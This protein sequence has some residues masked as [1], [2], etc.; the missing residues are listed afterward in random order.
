MP[1]SD[2]EEDDADAQKSANPDAQN[3]AS[4]DELSDWEMKEGEESSRSIVFRI[5]NYS[6]SL[7]ILITDTI[8]KREKRLGK[9]K[10]KKLNNADESAPE[11]EESASTHPEILPPSDEQSTFFEMN[12]SRPLM[13]VIHLRYVFKYYWSSASFQRVIS[14]NRRSELRAS[15]AD[16]GENNS[17]CLRR[18]WYLRLCRYRYR[19]NSRI[20]AADPRTITVQTEAIH[21]CYPV[22]HWALLEHT[23]DSLPPI[24]RLL[25]LLRI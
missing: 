7:L 4:D 21:S 10:R 23:I 20:Y 15:H 14:G 3:G 8:R 19:K 24:L 22:K 2:N 25:L 6:W 16:P 11:P 13:K 1:D 17:H 9:N 5:M 12:L 18:S